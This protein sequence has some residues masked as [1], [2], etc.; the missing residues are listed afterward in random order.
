L[1][2]ADCEAML[3]TQSEHGM[4]LGHAQGRDES[5]FPG[6]AGQVRDVSGAGDTV[7]WPALALALAAGADWEA[8]LRT[9]NAA[10]AVAGE[11]EGTANVTPAELRPKKSCPRHRLR[12]KKKSSRLRAAILESHLLQW[13]Q[14]GP[15][16]WLHQW[17]VFEHP[18]I[19]GH[20]KVLTAARGA[21]GPADRF[22]PQLATPRCGGLKGEGPSGPGRARARRGAGG[23][24]GRVDLVVLFEEDTPIK[25]IAQ[26][27]GRVCW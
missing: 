13:R 20:V 24:G 26:G 27:S 9:R 5:T 17:L 11:Q 8:A 21:C 25:L 16:H 22:G 3:V 23:V 1:H 4:A 12:P 2:L 15:A 10:A 18:A 7:G 6:A 14:A 19:P